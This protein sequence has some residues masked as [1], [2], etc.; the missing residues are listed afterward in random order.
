MSSRVTE[1]STLSA[2]HWRVLALLTFLMFISFVDRSNLSIAAPS[3][4]YDL[5]L[6]A[7]ELGVLLSAYF[8]ANTLCL[9]P[10]GWL[11]DRFDVTW[12]LAIGFFLWSAATTVTGLL[13]GF[14][15][16]LL[17]R[18]LV[19]AAESVV[20]PACSKVIAGH[21]PEH[22]R[23]LA[24]ASIVAGGASGPA[25]AT[26]VGGTLIAQFG[27]RWFFVCL[28]LFGLPWLLLWFR[29][30]PQENP[31]F[32]LKY[33][34]STGSVVKI[35]RQRSAW[36]TFIGMFGG[37]YMLYL[38]VTWLPF[39]LVHE[40]QFSLSST[41]MIGGAAFVLK[42]ISSIF[43]GHFSDRWISSG[44]TPTLVRK[45]FLGVGL[46]LAGMLL[47]LSEFTPDQA[48]IALLLGASISLG[49][50]APHFAAVPQTLA[51]PQLVGT[52]SSLQAFVAS[53]GGIVAPTLTGVV[54][55]RT[56]QFFWAFILTA[57]LG[58][59]GAISWLFLVGPIRPVDWLEADRSSDFGASLPEEV[60]RC[61]AR[62]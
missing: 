3:L 10:V 20:Y 9:L 34:V 13:H 19:G 32:A 35:L 48:C 12:I 44:G 61:K 31:V 16:L 26:F 15:A 38:L 60:G 43:S 62:G 42:A 5:H 45:T 54:V 17:I 40:R 33:R 47:V 29:W 52:W 1:T 18:L 36:G 53:F 28:G 41:G 58:W 59:I 21:F 8:W 30:R 2:R 14:I 57:L 55:N 23:G 7:S 37:N 50:A 4:K 56:G 22:L 25:V 11:I 49:L 6:S 46:S 39:Y 24:N 27:W 51:G